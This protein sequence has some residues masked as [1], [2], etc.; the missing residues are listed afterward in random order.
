MGFRGEFREAIILELVRQSAARPSE[1]K[2]DT[3][4]DG[5]VLI[6]GSVDIDAVIAAVMG[7]D[8]A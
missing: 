8:G 2:V 4:S 1:L 3:A 5:L 7:A 6:N